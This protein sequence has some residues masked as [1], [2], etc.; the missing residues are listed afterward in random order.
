M[1]LPRD[2]ENRCESNEQWFRTGAACK[3]QFSQS[4]TMS[5]NSHPIQFLDRSGAETV[6][7]VVR[8][9]AS[10]CA[11]WAKQSQVVLKHNDT[12]VSAGVSRI[13]THGESQRSGMPGQG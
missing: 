9:Q 13:C 11:Y 10:L 1:V 2:D 5:K 8:A 6:P 3:P 7:V 4:I 12:S